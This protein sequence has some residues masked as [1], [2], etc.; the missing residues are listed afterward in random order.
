MKRYFL[1]M[2]AGLIGL[3][4]CSDDDDKSK[5]NLNKLT[6]VTCYL[7]DETTPLYQVDIFY[8]ADGEIS[9]LQSL[10]KGKQEY[11]YVDKKLTISGPG[12][13]KT[14]YTLNNNYITQKK[15]YTTNPYAGNTVYV[16][17]EYSYTYK[18]NKLN[19]ADK[20]IR[21][22]L[23]GGTQYETRQYTG[24]DNYTWDGNNIS[25]FTR[26]MREMKYE[27]TSDECPDNLPFL[28]PN[29]FN[30]TGFEL[31]DP[32]NFYH[33]SPNTHLVSRAYWYNV[34]EANTICAEYIFD[35]TFL[36]E[37][38]TK[39]QIEEKNHVAEE[40]TGNNTYRISLEYNYPAK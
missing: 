14:E 37:Y 38:I 2:L 8:N 33:G 13:E 1:L 17:E 15:T 18:R 7:N 35:Y 28:V 27:Y 4:A 9:H 26:E 40:G 6:K 34:P 30:P 36:N 32:I 29:S 22:P 12:S 25:M 10:D 16:N 19:S 23:E 39:I 11:I 5:V 20:L 24:Y 21:W 3:T 31:F